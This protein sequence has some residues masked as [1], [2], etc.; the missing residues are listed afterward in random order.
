MEPTNLNTMTIASTSASTSTSTDS[1][2]ETTRYPK[3][4]KFIL[5]KPFQ[6]A[7]NDVEPW[8]FNMEEYFNNISL[9]I[10]KWICIVVSNMNG[11]AT[12]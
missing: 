2:I 6:G 11:N 8:L 5:P 4:F 1:R 9:S 7:Q 12:L 3:G 10:N